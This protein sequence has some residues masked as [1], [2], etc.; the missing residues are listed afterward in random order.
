MK[1]HSL[2]TRG[3]NALVRFFGR[4]SDKLFHRNKLGE[5]FLIFWL[6]LIICGITLM[7]LMFTKGLLLY[8]LAYIL[9][10]FG[11]MNLKRTADLG[12]AVYRS[13][14]QGNIKNA[15][16]YLRAMSG[17][18]TQ[19]YSV[20]EILSETV[21]AISKNTVSGM[22]AP[23]FCTVLGG[24]LFAMFYKVLFQIDKYLNLQKG[25]VCFLLKVIL[26]LPDKITALF[27]WV[28]GFLL[29]S[30]LKKTIKTT[31]ALR[32]MK[33][34]IQY[35]LALCAAESV[36][37]VSFDSPNEKPPKLS[38]VKK[39]IT[40]GYMSAVMGALLIASV[41]EIIKFLIWSLIFHEG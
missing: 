37:A 29:G 2:L 1:K 40:M 23:I 18:D 5:M 4:F 38:D 20:Q 3:I 12:R 13:L 28:S 32:K 31:F 27:F 22:I 36:L 26:Y 11:C 41:F 24:P 30:K 39:S 21:A 33:K 17:K 6:E 8:P 15:K 19:A 14:H 25:I 7:I 35:P 10:V 34:G 16:I 9:L